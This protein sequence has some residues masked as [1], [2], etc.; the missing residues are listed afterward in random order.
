MKVI[1][2]GRFLTQTLTGVQRYANEILLELDKIVGNDQYILA[3]PPNCKA[4][5]LNNIKVRKIGKHKDILWEQLD[6]AFYAKKYH[7]L[8]LNF[9]NVAPILYPG[10]VCIHDMNVREN[11]QFYSMRFRWWY[12]F[13]YFF[14]IKKAERIVT[15]SEYSK[16][17][18]LKYYRYCA[19]YIHV[20]PNSWQHLDRIKSDKKVLDKFDLIEGE[21]YFSLG[22]LELNKN[23]KW[24]TE[25]AKKNPDYIFAIAGKSIQRVSGD[26][27]VVEKADNV[28]LL[29]YVSDSEMKMLMKSCRAF[30]FPSLHEG[31]G[32]PPL[33]ALSQG[34]DV[35]ISGLS[36]LPEI[37]EDAAQ[38]IDPFNF[39]YNIDDFKGSTMEEK[40]KILNKYSWKKSA[41]LWHNLCKEV[42]DKKNI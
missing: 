11:P 23:L 37:F 21:Y 7:L 19:N 13:V 28:K 22:S 31:F 10:I 35:I 14:M 38:Y 15:V 26:K 39:Q 5:T 12:F 6:L 29:G 18:I 41:Q 16:K 24:I 33:E 36:S 1:I 34:A 20:I 2:N 9:C 4:P 27:G 32:I 25:T 17:E 40:R 30:L 42:L 3:I 8:L